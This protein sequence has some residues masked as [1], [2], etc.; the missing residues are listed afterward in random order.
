MHMNYYTYDYRD[1]LDRSDG[2]FATFS[3][4]LIKQVRG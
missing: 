2:M 4:W 3:A 1:V